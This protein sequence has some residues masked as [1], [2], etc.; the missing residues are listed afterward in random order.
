[1]N[2]VRCCWS[3]L[4]QQ[5]YESILHSQT[6]LLFPCIDSRRRLCQLLN[7]RNITCLAV[8]WKNYLTHNLGPAFHLILVLWLTVIR[9]LNYWG[10]DAANLDADALILKN[11][12][13]LHQKFIENDL[14]GSRGIY[15]FNLSWKWGATI[16]GGV[17]MIRSTP[18]SGRHTPSHA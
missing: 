1:M 17:F 8:N 5:R 16:C 6:S 2:I 3:G 14:L 12:E 11:P 15:P 7:K 9:L 13:S 10:Y 18:N 4:S